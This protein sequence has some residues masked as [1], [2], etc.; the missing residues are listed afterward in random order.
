MTC[1]V[2]GE[3]LVEDRF[4]DWTARWRCLKC[5]R[6]QHPTPANRTLPASH[7]RDCFES[8]EPDYRDDEVHLG[9]ESFVRSHVSPTTFT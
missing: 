2:C 4:L 3:L 7:E 1:S 8:A 5:G 6:V 9:S